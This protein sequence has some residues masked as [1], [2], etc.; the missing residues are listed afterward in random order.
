MITLNHLVRKATDASAEAFRNYWLGE[1]AERSVSIAPKLGIRNLSKCE[2]LHEDEVN[3]LLQQM[4]GTA[5]DAYDFVDQMVINDLGD[6][7]KG[8]V[9]PEVRASLS[10]MHESEGRWLDPLRS[11]YWFSI[12][13]P[14]IFTADRCVAT[15]NNT[16]LKGFYVPRRLPHL[17]LGEAQ[18][19][20]NSCHGALAR[21][22]VEFLPYTKYVQGHRIESHV[23]EE[24]KALLGGTFE[25]IDAIIGQAEAWIDR[26]IVP[27]LQGPETDRMMRMLVNDIDLFVDAGTSHLFATKEHCILDRPVIIEPVPT[28]FNVD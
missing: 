21:Q 16:L 9:E 18:L 24:L 7:K 3:T 11:D 1:H 20:W 27:S 5:T 8:L 23:C 12:E 25:N 2:T 26:R 19:H 4:Y 6:F 10:E 13:I 17:S 15:W 22:F 14:Q 28:L